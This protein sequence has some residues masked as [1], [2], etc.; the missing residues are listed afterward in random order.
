M[1]FRMRSTRGFAVIAMLLNMAFAPAASAQDV[2][3]LDLAF[4]NG[5]LPTSG[6]GTVPD[7]QGQRL[8]AGAAREPAKLARRHP[9]R[10]LR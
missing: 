2:M 4:K 9:R 10:A 6:Q 1:T 8:N 3:Q 5:Q 7:L